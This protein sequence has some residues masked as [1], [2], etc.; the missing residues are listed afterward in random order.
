MSP[1]PKHPKTEPPVKPEKNIPVKPDS[2]PDPTKHNEPES[3]PT[4]IEQPGK[5][6][7]TRI[8]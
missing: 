2:N 7:P 4:R 3:D 5:L 6:D 1:D 8:G